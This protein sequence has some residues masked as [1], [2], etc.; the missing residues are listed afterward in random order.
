METT[1]LTS[2]SVTCSDAV[3][4]RT[5]TCLERVQ[6]A[7]T[8]LSRLLRCKQLVTPPGLICFLLAKGSCICLISHVPICRSI[9]NPV[10]VLTEDRCYLQIL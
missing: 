2:K 10:T 6:A 5:V 3:N 1:D 4:Q 9:Q 8:V 7:A